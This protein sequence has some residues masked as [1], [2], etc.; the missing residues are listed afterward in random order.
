MNVAIIGLGNIGGSLPN[1]L[2]RA[3]QI[4]KY[5]Q[6]TLIQIRYPLQNPLVN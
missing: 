1:L 2:G 5:M 6:S 3:Y 4:I